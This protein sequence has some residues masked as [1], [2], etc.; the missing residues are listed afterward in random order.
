MQVRKERKAALACCFGTCK[1]SVKTCL[2]FGLLINYLTGTK[3]YGYTRS[4]GSN[5]V[6][7][8]IRLA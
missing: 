1:L 5:T 8:Q 7:A 2:F 3:K 4:P 6:L